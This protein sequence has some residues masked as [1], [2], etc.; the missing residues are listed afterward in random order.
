MDNEN[1][2]NNSISSMNSS[3]QQPKEPK[4]IIRQPKR[5]TKDKIL[6]T[7]TLIVLM[8]I[9]AILFKKFTVRFMRQL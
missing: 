2:D 5:T 6:D 4:I 3:I 9:F 7:L 8:A 1:Q